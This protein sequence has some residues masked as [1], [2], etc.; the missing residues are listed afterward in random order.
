[1][2]PQGVKPQ[3][4]TFASITAEFL[5][6]PWSDT[7]IGPDAYNCIGFCY[8]FLKRTGKQVDD[9]VWMNQQIN[10]INYLEFRAKDPK[11][12]V[13][14]LIDVFLHIGE[15]VPV[16][17]KT[18]GD[19]IIF[20]DQNKRFHPA[21]YTGNGQFMTSHRELGVRV[22]TFEGDAIKPVLVRR[23]R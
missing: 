18:A 20:Q 11:K 3:K 4:E 22:F 9:D 17:K 12:T 14:W 13:E 19:F 21:I 1:M 23:L 15:E 16:N 2:K 7:G 10:A 8:A 5:G 6:K